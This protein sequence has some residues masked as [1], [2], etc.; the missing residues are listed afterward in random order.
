[1]GVILPVFAERRLY[2]DDFLEVVVA[3]I[4]S[5]LRYGWRGRGRGKRLRRGHGVGRS[6]QGGDDQRKIHGRTVND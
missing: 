5:A 4:A 2:E 1:M 6:S 3:G